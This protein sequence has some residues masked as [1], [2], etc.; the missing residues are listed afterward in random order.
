MVADGMGGLNAGELAAQAVAEAFPKTLLQAFASLPRLSGKPL[1]EAIKTAIIGFSAELRERGRQNPG[2]RGMGST[3]V[4]ALLRGR[5]AYI[6]HLG[7]SRAYLLEQGRLQRLTRDHTLLAVLLEMK[8][9]SPEEAASH[10]G[11]HSLT[12]YVGMET[13][14][15]A[16]IRALRCKSSGR[17]LLCSDGLTGMLPDERIQVI[18]QDQAQPEAACRSLVAAA[19]EAG[20]EDNITAMV[21]DWSSARRSAS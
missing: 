8:K 13:K 15:L 3:L 21:I 14:A 5:Y 11:R 2:L 7:D 1:Q 18:L 10:P 19:N 9:I 17:L 16:D 4:M 6:A 20:G 12:R